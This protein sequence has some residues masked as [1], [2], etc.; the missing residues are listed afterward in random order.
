MTFLEQ[1][2][3]SFGNLTGVP[4]YI[5]LLVLAL[6]GA[7]FVGYLLQGSRVAWQLWAAVRGIRMLSAAKKPVDPKEIAKLL[8]KE[9]N[10]WRVPSLLSKKPEALSTEMN[11]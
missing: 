8:K 9:K 11:S 3:P 1:L 7:F 10:M 6:S 2:H 5:F 4:L